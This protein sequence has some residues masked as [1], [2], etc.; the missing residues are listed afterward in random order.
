MIER[1]LKQYLLRDAG[2]YPVVTLTGPRQSGKTTLA[3]ATFPDYEYVSLEESESRLFAR[4]DPKGFLRRYPGPVIIDEAQRVPEIFSDIQRSVDEDNTSG[5]YI[6]TGSHNFLLMEQVSQTLAGRCAVLHLLPFSRAELDGSDL[7]KPKAPP[8]LFCNRSTRLNK[9]ETV[10]TG[11]YPRIHDQKIPPEIWLSD[12]VRTYLERDVRSLS[13][14]GDLETFERFV[15]LC[16]GR[17]GQILNYSAIAD[18]C[19]ISVD[20]AK[21]WVSILKTSFIIFLLTPHHRNY[22]KR[23]IKSPKLYFYDSGLTC[24]LLGIRDHRQLETHPLRGPLFENF[25]LGE[26]MKA[27]MHHRIS[28]PLFFWRDRTGHEIDVI[29][30]EGTKL[31]PVEIKSGET[32]SRNMLES[33]TW[34]CRQA[35]RPLETATLLYGGTDFQERKGINIRPWFSI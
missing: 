34:W 17:S 31:F 20:T 18:D 23:L 24:F 19:G 27:Y 22:N 30:E 9:W 12:Y 15:K 32:I 2:Y 1:F 26:I 33:L 3:R 5:R 21:R 7:G 13:N 16:A 10:R 25:I 6:L 8:A 29:I 14:I 35:D 11:F 28:A 4:E